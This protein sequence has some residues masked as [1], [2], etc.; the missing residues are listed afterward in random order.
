MQTDEL[1]QRLMALPLP[2]R[3]RVAQKLWQSIDDGLPVSAADEH[4]DARQAAVRRDAELTCGTVVGRSHE[5]VM[6][7]VRRALE[8]G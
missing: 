2:D 6:E 8:C 7:A 3:V 5:Q 4:K 1:V